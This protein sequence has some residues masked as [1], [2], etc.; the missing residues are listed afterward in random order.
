MRQTH[1]PWP[2]ECWEP[3]GRGSRGRAC[4]RKPD[5]GGVRPLLSLKSS[6]ALSQLAGSSWATPSQ[7]RFFSW[8][9]C[10]DWKSLPLFPRQAWRPKGIY[11][12]EGTLPALR[13]QNLSRGR[14]ASW[15]QWASEGCPPWS[16]N[17]DVGAARDRTRQRGGDVAVPGSWPPASRS[18]FP[19]QPVVISKP[20][21]S[22]TPGRLPRGCAS[23]PLTPQ[24]EKKQG[25]A[26]TA[27]SQGAPT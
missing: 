19:W 20:A 6:A 1:C 21:P 4:G 24:T 18:S 17:G 15:L 27:G 16:S 14:P 23:C 5:L 13:G 26:V 9:P 3:V 2:R 22:P 25:H 8:F 10:W 7:T 11:C 12:S